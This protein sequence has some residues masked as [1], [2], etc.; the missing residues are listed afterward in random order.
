M[1]CKLPPSNFV[2]VLNEAKDAAEYAV[3]PVDAG[4]ANIDV[5]ILL[6]AGSPDMVLS[7]IH[8]SS[9]HGTRAIGR[10][11]KKYILYPPNMSYQRSNRTAQCVAIVKV[12][13]SHG[14]DAV[15]ESLPER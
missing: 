8:D 5:V 9:L 7:M 3:G 6:C 13:K 10:K 1:P 14:F 2:H 12:L 11:G 15:V 4:S